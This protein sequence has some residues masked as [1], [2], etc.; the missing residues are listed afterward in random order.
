MS[1]N[2][3]L[4]LIVICFLTLININ[5][6]FSQ[7]N[8]KDTLYVRIDKLKPAKKNIS[9]HNGNIFH[10]NTT[11]NSKYKNFGG[12]LGIET[13]LIAINKRAIKKNKLLSFKELNNLLNDD[14]LNI[15]LNCKIYFVIT[16]DQNN[17]L[18]ILLKPIL[19]PELNKM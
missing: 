18:V 14:F 19:P 2:M 3:K 5:S 11:I 13:E 12:F 17:F 7:N 10:F 16:S 4:K 6:A 8:F 1:I 15:Y 9:V